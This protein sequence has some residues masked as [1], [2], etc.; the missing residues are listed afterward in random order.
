MWEND[1]EK[2]GF[3]GLGVYG[4]VCKLDGLTVD[5]ADGVFVR[6]HIRQQSFADLLGDMAV[7]SLA[8]NSG[9]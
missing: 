2:H 3:A 6:D 7:E 1:E 4:G 8:L 5:Q 9:Q